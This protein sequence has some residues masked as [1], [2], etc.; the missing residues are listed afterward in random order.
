MITR[1]A[2]A[3]PIGYGAMCL[4]SLVAIMA[5]VAA[6]TLDPGIYLSM[7]IKGEPAATAAQVTALG[8]PITVEQMDDLAH[9][10]GEHTLFGRT[11]GAATLAVGMAVI[12][13]KAVNERWLDL[14][15]HFAIM[16]EALFI[17]TTIDAGTRVGRYILQDVLGRAW[18]PLGDT[19]RFG[20]NLLA[21]VLMVGGWGYFLVQGVRDPL[22]GINSLWPLFGIANQMLA[23]I[24]LCLATTIILKSQ[25]IPRPTGRARPRPALALVTFLPLVWLLTVT[26]TA[27]VQKIGHPDPRIGF[28]SQARQLSLQLPALEDSLRA[29]RDTGLAAS[30]EAAEKQL[31]R[32]RGLRFNNLLDAVVAGVF[33]VL[34]TVI[35]L[36][37]VREWVLL[38]ARKKLAELRE[39]PP[40][41]LPDYAVVEHRPFR[42]FSFLGLALALARELSGEAAADRVREVAPCGCELA[43]KEEDSTA[44]PRLAAYLQTTERKYR[45][46]HRCC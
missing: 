35:V 46:I 29:A 7:N 4:E 14:W 15:Y 22:G 12:F 17:L 10:I 37:S 32:T 34:A 1:E 44:D 28:L 40:V 16:F 18:K 27:G 5:I 6:C 9:R 43:G 25:L 20:P 26:F 21:S 13:S 2:Y 38:L 3:R 39:S 42:L 30:I 33:L 23:A 19:R 24:A 41:W 11:G 8:Y 31:K 45:G 36:L